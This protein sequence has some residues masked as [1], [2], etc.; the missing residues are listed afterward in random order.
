MRRPLI[1]FCFA[2]AIGA[3]AHAGAWLQ[4]KGE[5]LFIA[6]RSYFTSN[7]YYDALGS[8]QKQPRFDKWETQPYVEYGLAERITIGGTVF[9]QNLE[10]SGHQK[11]GIADPELFAR[12]VLWQG[13]TQLIS[14]QPFVKFPSMFRNETVPRGGSSSTDYGLSLLYGKNLHLL[15]TRDYLDVSGGYRIRDSQLQNQWHADAALGVGILQSWTIIPS[16]HSVFAAQKQTQ[17]FSQTGDL[18]YDLI[19]AEIA[20]NYRFNEKRSLQI[21]VFNHV[22]G[23][24]TGNGYGISLGIAQKF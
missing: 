11:I 2:L 20:A 18:D 9:G 14:A 12:T 8:K 21:G 16:V 10:Q 4:P 13:Q 24:Q 3:S 17:N 7:A 19:K 23:R 6:Q 5:G 15:S 1:V 22:W